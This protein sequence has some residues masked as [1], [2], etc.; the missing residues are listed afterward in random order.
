[1]A[2]SIDWTI[3]AKMVGVEI[4]EKFRIEASKD[5]RQ[6]LGDC[7]IED[8]F[9]DV[10]FCIYDNGFIICNDYRYTSDDY[11]EDVFMSIIVGGILNGLIT[12]KHKKYELKDGDDYYYVYMDKNSYHI[13]DTTYMSDNYFDL[14]N[15]VNGNCFKTREEALNAADRIYKEFKDKIDSVDKSRYI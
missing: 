15:Y 12:I 2:K 3:I 7:G 11:G 10:E 13:T 5:I 9:Y 14:M 1:M 4:G 6:F 8:D